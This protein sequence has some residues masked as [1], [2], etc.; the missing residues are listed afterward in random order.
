MI[1]VA[2][3]QPMA[4]ARTTQTTWLAHLIGPAHVARAAELASHGDMT[5]FSLVG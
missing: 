1:S 5:E 2:S 3:G 4:S